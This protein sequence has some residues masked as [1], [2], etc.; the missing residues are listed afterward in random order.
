METKNH[1]VLHY[2]G[3][4]KE[5]LAFYIPFFKN[6]TKVVDYGCG[7]GD[8]LDLCRSNNIVAEGVDCNPAA[9]EI[10]K[11]R[12][13]TCHPSMPMSKLSEYDGLFMCCVIEHINREQLWNILSS[14]NGLVCIQAD[15]PRRV[16]IPWL[17]KRDSFWD[18]FEH[19]RPYT[20]IALQKL[21][22]A[23]GFD[24]VKEGPVPQSPIG[25][26]HLR[27]WLTRKYMALMYNLTGIYG[28]HFS[29]GAKNGNPTV[30]KGT[31]D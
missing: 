25:I 19:V 31:P 3:T 17:L 11:S 15:E 21:L 29:V 10:C 8:F 22:V 6:C 7:K 9:V 24:I 13:L 28:S 1:N 23:H 14:F 5:N 27:T 30:N 26:R 12:G 2:E 20:P 18:D 16:F 4:S